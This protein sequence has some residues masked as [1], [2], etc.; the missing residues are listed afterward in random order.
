[1]RDNSRDAVAKGRWR[2]VNKLDAEK[3]QAIRE[4]LQGKYNVPLIRK[5]A[6]EYGVTAVHIE[7]VRNGTCWPA[8]NAAENAI[9]AN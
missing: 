2:T 8:E 6:K 4:R 5:L 9:A 3:A 7:N 1:M